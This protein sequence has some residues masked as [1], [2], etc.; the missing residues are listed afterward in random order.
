M[1]KA[2]TAKTPRA[3]RENVEK[4]FLAILASWRFNF[5]LIAMLIAGCDRDDQAIRV[6]DIPKEA[7]PQQQMPAMDNVATATGSA[8]IH[9]TV[10]QGWTAK[11]DSQGM[12]FATFAVSAERPD[13][14][15][16]VVA[17]GSGDVLANVNRWQQQLGLPPS[18]AEELDSVVK[19]FDV[20]G[21]SASEVD[22][23]G[24]QTPPMRM[25]AAIVPHQGR[26]WFFKLMGPAEVVAT[27]KEKF[28]AFVRSVEFGEGQSAKPQAA[29][30][31]PAE[32]Q[33]NV[34]DSWEKEEAAPMRYVS[35]HAG[36]AEIVVSKFPATGSGSYLDNVNRWRNQV[37]L[38][39]ITDKDPQASQDIHVGGSEAMLFDL[40]GPSKRLIVAVTPQGED[41][42]YF[43]MIG[44]GDAVAQQ[45]NA[46]DQFLQSVQFA[47]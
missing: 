16:T 21:E 43:K 42:W 1:Q 39:A 47:K 23:N 31:T 22:L 4:K 17:L 32:I 9:W 33:Y 11:A 24:T 38:P 46:F 15:A 25:L 34:P 30:Q 14:V 27:Q 3:P 13:V 20:A 19:H 26:F 29:E 2:L 37:E 6:Y 41:F 8:E 18:K 45:K 35:F 12:R 36:E 40:A 10:P 5:L 28:E 7:E 44:P